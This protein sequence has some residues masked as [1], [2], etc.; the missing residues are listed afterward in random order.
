MIVGDEGVGKRSLVRSF[1]GPGLHSFQA[2]ILGRRS[3]QS[4]VVTGAGK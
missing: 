1:L 3:S 4:S 2:Q